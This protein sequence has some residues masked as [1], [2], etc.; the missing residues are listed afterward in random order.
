MLT[1]SVS[2]KMRHLLFLSSILSIALLNLGFELKTL[3]EWKFVDFIWKNS[4]HRQLAIESGSYIVNACVLYDVDMAPDGRVFMTAVRNKGVPASLM[5]VTKKMGEGG[6]LLRPYPDW[7]WYENNKCDGII[8]VYRIYIICNHLF[9]LDCGKIGDDKICP[10][11][12]LIFN[13]STNKL[14]RRAII[15]D[16]VATNRNGTGLLVTPMVH[17][18]HCRNIAYTATVYMA[19]IKGYGLVVWN[20]QTSKFCRFESDYMK[21]IDTTFTVQNESFSFNDGILGLTLIRKDL[22]YAALAGDNIYKINNWTL[23]K[24]G[25]NANETGEL[26]QMAGTLTGQ[27]APIASKDCAIFFSNIPQTSIMCAD[28]SDEINPNTMQLLNLITIINTIFII[29]NKY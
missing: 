16:N 21:P 7:S 20:A 14:V 11:Q 19:D 26:T 10:A 2:L 1:I 23:Q 22:Y 28:T 4:K 13:L 12:L 18:R 17:A 29:T 24:C 6:P 3:R 8:G 5:T 25:L 15:P 27:T 9:V